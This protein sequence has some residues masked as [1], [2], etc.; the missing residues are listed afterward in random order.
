MCDLFFTFIS[1]YGSEKNIEMGQKL[2]VTVKYTVEKK[3]LPRFVAHSQVL[4]YIT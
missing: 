1:V 4:A 2:T 3:R